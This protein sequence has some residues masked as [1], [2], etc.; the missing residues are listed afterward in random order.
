METSSKNYNQLFY[1][2]L[3]ASFENLEEVIFLYFHTI[4]K[5]LFTKFRNI[6]V[7][8]CICVRGYFFKFKFSNILMSYQLKTLYSNQL[9]LIKNVYL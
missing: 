5:Y 3:I 4:F 9:I 8:V 6:R 7:F 1:K 2:Q